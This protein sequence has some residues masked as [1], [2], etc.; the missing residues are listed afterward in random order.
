[1]YPPLSRTDIECTLT[2]PDSEEF[3]PSPNCQLEDIEMTKRAGKYTGRK[4]SLTDG[5]AQQVVDRLAAG[6]SAAALANEFGIGRAA[7]YVYKNR[8]SS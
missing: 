3:I 4:P 1:M 6:E 2:A 7:I 5:Q 8:L